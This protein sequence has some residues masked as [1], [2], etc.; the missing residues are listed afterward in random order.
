MRHSLQRLSLLVLLAFMLTACASVQEVQKQRRIDDAV[1]THVRL[2]MEYLQRDNPRDAKRHLADA[3][4]LRPENAMVHNALAIFYRYL[5]DAAQQEKHLKLA[6][7]Y[8]DD[9]APAHNNYGIMLTQQERYREAI[10]QFRLAAVDLENESSGLAYANMG[11][12]YQLLGEGDKAL[13]AFNTAIRL[14]SGSASVYLSIVQIYFQRDDYSQAQHY[15]AR[16]T[17]LAN[18][19]TAAGLWLGIRLANHS[20]DK[21][22]RASYELALENLY[23]ESSQYQAWGEWRRQQEEGK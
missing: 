22:A 1:T 23:P 15:Y 18:P 9:Y 21:D 8:N 5:H 19:Q 2:A 16:Y 7:A 11:R 13:Q 10:E 6:I 14:N 12:C 3:L 17:E 20:G 4:E